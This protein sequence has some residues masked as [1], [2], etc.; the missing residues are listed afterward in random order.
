MSA[1]PPKRVL[2]LALELAP[3]RIR[4]NSILPGW[5]ETERINDLMTARAVRNGTTAEEE[6]AKQA[7]NIPLGR[8]ATPA[9][10]ANAAAFLVSPAASYITGVMLLVDGGQYPAT[11]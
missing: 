4:F 5:T 7:A 1:H 11:F 2:T 10:F 8:M 3:D 6:I 9:E